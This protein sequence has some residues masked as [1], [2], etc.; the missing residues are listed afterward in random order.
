M[1]LSIDIL[2]LTCKNELH[3]LFCLT[4]VVS[5]LPSHHQFQNFSMFEDWFVCVHG[6]RVSDCHTK[7]KGTD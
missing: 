5:S 2:S 3:L 1:P 6:T 4:Y 7:V